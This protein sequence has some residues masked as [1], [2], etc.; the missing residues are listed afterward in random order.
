MTIKNEITSEKEIVNEL[1]DQWKQLW[2]RRRDDL[3]KAE[4]IATETYSSLCVE[5]GTIIHATRDFKPLSFKEI[6]I[7][8]KIGN[9]GR[10]VSPAPAI[11][12]WAKFVKTHIRPQNNH[13]QQR[14]IIRHEFRKERMQSNKKRCGWLNK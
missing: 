14:D 12:G 3:V 2:N 13:L 9:Y 4:S 6:L 1:R 10:Y 5:R 8:H 11:G 7:S